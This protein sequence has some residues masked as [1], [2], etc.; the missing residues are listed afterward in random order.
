M[1][2]QFTG[3]LLLVAGLAFLSTSKAA[4][5]GTVGVEATW[6]SVTPT[7]TLDV[8]FPNAMV[9]PETEGTT[10]HESP[11][12]WKPSVAGSFSWLNT[13]SGVFTPSKPYA[14]GTEY[15]LTLR[16]GLKDL[17]GKCVSVM[18]PET[19]VTPPLQVTGYATTPWNAVFDDKPSV[20]ISF[21]ANVLPETLEGQLVS[22]CGRSAHCLPHPTGDSLSTKASHPR[23]PT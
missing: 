18:S 8:Q 10:A 1:H 5:E 11:L 17:A 9:E 22:G 16:K 13:R 15:S 20:L 4:A 19:F 6:D 12:I 23:N 2:R 21:N 7:T 3:L 14:L